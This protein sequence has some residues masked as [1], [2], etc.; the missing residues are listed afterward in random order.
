MNRFE[1]KVAWVTGGAGGI[2]RITSEQFA[3][4]GAKVAVSDIDKDA[5]EAVVAEIEAAGGEAASVP[6]D[7][8]N[9]ADCEEAVSRIVELW[10][11]LD[12]VF[13]NAGVVGANLA[14]FHDLD[15]WMRIVDINLTG[16]YRTTRAAIPGAAQLRWRGDR[17]DL[18]GGG[19][20]GQRHALGVLHGQDR[21]AG[22]VPIGGA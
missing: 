12:A 11:R 7:V 1:G 2:G 9:L 21:P 3:A 13:A 17:D 18:L 5:A 8:T 14:E 22:P 19:H 10:G 6:C 20:R 15:D 4:E 16:V